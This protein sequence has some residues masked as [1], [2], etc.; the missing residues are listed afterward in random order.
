MTKEE[1]MAIRAGVFLISEKK[2]VIKNTQYYYRLAISIWFAV[3]RN[4]N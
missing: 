1:G 3:S 4:E 2:N